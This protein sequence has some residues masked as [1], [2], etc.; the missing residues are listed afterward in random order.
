MNEN[1]K[2]F[3]LM[4]YGELSIKTDAS[5]RWDRCK[6]TMNPLALQEIDSQLVLSAF[7]NKLMRR[8]EKVINYVTI[9]W[10][11]TKFLLTSLLRN[12]MHLERRITK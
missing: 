2:M 1:Y 12:V 6:E 4:Q 5:K 3:R 9:H 8:R 10:D 7:S 11:I